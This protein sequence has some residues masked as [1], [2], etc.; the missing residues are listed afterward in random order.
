MQI[1]PVSVGKKQAQG[2]E[3]QLG[4]ASLVMVVGSKGYLMC[5]YLNLETAEK[6]GDCAAII[7]GV[8]TIEDLLKAPVV[9][10][11]SRAKKAGIRK[12]MTGLKALQKLT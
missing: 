1:Y 10:L 9:S 12:G 8:K 7:T 3:I 6:L 4:K 2:V 11:T 5:G